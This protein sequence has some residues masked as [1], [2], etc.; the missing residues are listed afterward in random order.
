M[1]PEELQWQNMMLLT[2]VQACIGLISQPIRGIWIEFENGREFKIHFD[3]S[4]LNEELSE[5]IESIVFLTASYLELAH[6]QRVDREIHL[7]GA[8]P[9]ADQMHFRWVFLPKS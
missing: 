2:V 9:K 6:A 5:D 4:E 7:D 1:D 3:V 8:R